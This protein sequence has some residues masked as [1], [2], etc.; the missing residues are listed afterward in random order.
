M[1]LPWALLAVSATERIWWPPVASQA[2]NRATT[3]PSQN[4]RRS[5]G[6]SDGSPLTA[7]AAGAETSIAGRARGTCTADAERAIA[8][9]TV[10]YF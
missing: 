6:D 8:T 1:S 5:A 2:T 3:L 4:H 10:L 9:S 7:G